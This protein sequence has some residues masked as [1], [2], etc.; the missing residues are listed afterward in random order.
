MRTPLHLSELVALQCE[1]L[2][3]SKQVQKREHVCS[4]TLA[5]LIEQFITGRVPV[6]QTARLA[7]T[8]LQPQSLSSVIWLSL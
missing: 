2:E 5:L 8:A 6:I 3:C 7:L 4:V 1:T